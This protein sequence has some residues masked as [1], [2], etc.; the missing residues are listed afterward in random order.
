ML[1]Q[2]FKYVIF[3]RENRMDINPKILRKI[4]EMTEDKP[5]IGEFIKALLNF[6]SEGKGWF[7]DQYNK[8]LEDYSEGRV[9]NEN[10]KD[11][12]N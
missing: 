10:P 7:K 2:P 9:I 5:P 11:N 1:M 8:F 3:W 4:N 12:V 6:E